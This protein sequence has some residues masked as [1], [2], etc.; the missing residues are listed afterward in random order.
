MSYESL[1]SKWSLDYFDWIAYI[2]TKAKMPTYQ[3]YSPVK[4]ETIYTY[5]CALKK[6]RKQYSQNW[7][8]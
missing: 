4:K 2:S 1:K 8:N 6:Q 5:V 3:Q 7:A